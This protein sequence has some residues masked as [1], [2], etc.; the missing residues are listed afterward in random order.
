MLTQCLAL[1]EVARGGIFD[2]GLDEYLG[3]LSMITPN[4]LII[5]YKN[6]KDF[7]EFV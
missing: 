5:K 6:N 3:D 1:A 4:M 2:P 7:I